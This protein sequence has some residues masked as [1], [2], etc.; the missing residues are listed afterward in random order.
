[1][2]KIRTISLDGLEKI[3]SGGRS[4]IYQLPDN[5]ILKVYKG[6]IELNEINRMINV[7]QMADKSGISVVRM[8]E[9][10]KTP[11]GLGV[12]SDY[13]SGLSL[14][15]K[16]R[17]DPNNF[18]KYVHE[19]VVLSKQIS[20]TTLIQEEICYT[21]DSYSGTLNHLLGFYHTMK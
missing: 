11:D 17:F 13:V 15:E 4:E 8:Y 20:H 14:A 2:N 7:V 18:E 1:M 5:R 10:V 21:N 3:N 19:F 12:I 6:R 9:A 16:M